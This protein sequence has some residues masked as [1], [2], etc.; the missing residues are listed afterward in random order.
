MRAHLRKW[1]PLFVF[2]FFTLT[3][4]P[5]CAALSPQKKAPNPLEEITTLA[6]NDQLETIVLFA[7][8]NLQGALLPSEPGRGGAALL[9]AYYKIAQKG[10]PNTLLWLDAGNLRSKSPEDQFNH[11]KLFEDFIAKSGISVSLMGTE[12]SVTSQSAQ[13]L[14]SESETPPVQLPSIQELKK[15]VAGHILLPSGRV[16]VGVISANTREQVEKESAAARTEGAQLVVWLSQLP[17]HCSPHVDSAPSIFQKPGEP[18]GFCEGALNDVVT[19]LPPETIDAVITSGGEEIVQQYIYPRFSA[20]SVAGIPVVETTPFG[21]D[22]DLIYL[23]YDLKNHRRLLAK[24]RIEGPVAVSEGGA[25]FHGKN[26]VADSDIQALSKPAREWMNTQEKVVLAQSSI[27]MAANSS[28]ES[29]V[30]DLIADAV[31]A[32]TQ[33][34]F[35]LVQPG[36]FKNAVGPNSIHPGPVTQASLI[37]ALPADSPIVV[38]PVTGEELKLMIQIS[39]NGS[40]GFSSVS[41]LY[42][43]LIKPE[44][45]AKTIDL[46]GN[47]HTSLWEQNRLLEVSTAPL[48]ASSD[49]FSH[50]SS[51]ASS[52][53]NDGD[54]AIH[55]KRTYKLAVPAFL[56]HGGDD[57]QWL[58]QH[59]ALTYRIDPKATFP[60]TRELVA[61]YLKTQG[62]VQSMPTRIHFETPSKGKSKK[63]RRRKRHKKPSST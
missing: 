29:P 62:T 5:G 40:R 38:I 58:S 18:T 36:F 41:G 2:S 42:L 7:T 56:V 39:E 60:S 22:I 45:E 52:H 20:N 37:R 28:G 59:F 13:P 43:R 46:D 23:T 49:S 9:E 19:Q 50:T 47:H 32:Q 21:K 57:W 17:I 1:L 35:A 4:W 11:G 27:E 34:D 14:A 3:Q 53:V 12:T 26:A 16:R 8:G 61:S 15:N 63:S 31:R 55:T 33:S 30:G 25:R 51:R 24:T 54:T 48:T 10:F 6:S 44:L